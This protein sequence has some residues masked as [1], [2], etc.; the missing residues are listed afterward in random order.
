MYIFLSFFGGGGGSRGSY[1]YSSR[2]M[3]SLRKVAEKK[4]PLG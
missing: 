2:G 4:R 3:K 1:F